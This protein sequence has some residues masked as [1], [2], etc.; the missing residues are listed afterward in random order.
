[1]GHLFSESLFVPTNPNRDVLT[2]SRTPIIIRFKTFI[3]EGGGLATPKPN[4]SPYPKNGIQ[5]EM[6][7]LPEI[8]IVE[9]IARSV[10]WD[11]QPEWSTENGA[12]E[13]LSRAKRYCA[14]QSFLLSWQEG[15]VPVGWQRARKLTDYD[16]KYPTEVVDAAQDRIEQLIIER[17][18]AA[19]ARIQ[20][21]ANERRESAKRGADPNVLQRKEVI[22]VRRQLAK[23]NTSYF[24]MKDAV[25]KAS[26]AV[27]ELSLRAQAL[28]ERL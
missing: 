7:P 16:G 21:A 22:V 3:Q 17:N 18:N 23:F 13:Y 6:S 9:Q 24:E 27:A 15:R 2:Q 25:D 14:A 26:D 10:E 19:N 4:L 8:P 11:A 5:L 28:Q 12:D 1:M 20:Q